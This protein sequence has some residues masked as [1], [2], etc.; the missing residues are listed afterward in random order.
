M[1]LLA[2][3]V[4]AARPLAD[5]DYR[6]AFAPAAQL[7]RRLDELAHDGFTCVALARPEPGS[8]VPG[9]AAILAR[10]TAATASSAAFSP[11]TRSRTA[12]GGG[13][14]PSTSPGGSPRR[15]RR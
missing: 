12:R 8:N 6:V 15:R 11:T 1:A 3:P 10:T 4:V 7:E 13:C 5:G 9:V 2:L 14:R